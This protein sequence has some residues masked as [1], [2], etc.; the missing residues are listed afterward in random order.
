M[1]TTPPDDQQRYHTIH[2]LD[3]AW[4]PTTWEKC[5]YLFAKITGNDGPVVAVVRL[6][7]VIGKAGFTRSGITI[8][9]VAAVLETAFGIKKAEE[10]AIIINSPGGSPVQSQLIANRIR[11]LAA[12]KE[13]KV[14]V[15]IEDVGAS[16][17]YWL[18]L[19]ADEIYAM[20]A[21]IIGSIGVISA[22]FGFEGAIAKLGI[23]RRVYTQG[24]HKNILDPFLPEKKED[25]EILSSLQK[26]I[27]ELFKN[28]VS[29]RRQDKISKKD[30]KRIFSGEFWTGVKAKELGLIDHIGDIYQVMLE[31]Y[32]KDVKLK[33]ISSSRSW[34]KKQ[35]GV[36][37]FKQRVDVTIDAILERLTTSF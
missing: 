20:D 2:D 4:I 3:D 8:E 23:Q 11:Q 33:T 16:G 10:V 15:F 1:K 27:H 13:K 26:D 12:E 36:M 14:T 28:Y 21:S 32:G 29:S 24:E 34:I 19:A 22:G 31:R 25:V 37:S 7:G 5:K 18:A 6:S 17:G 30:E 35:L 9:D